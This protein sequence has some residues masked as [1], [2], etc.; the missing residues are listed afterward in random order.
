M[1]KIWRWL[2]LSGVVALS[3]C[4][5]VRCG[6]PMAEITP[7]KQTS[8]QVQVIQTDPAQRALW[9]K[10]TVSETDRLPAGQLSSRKSAGQ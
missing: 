4:Q 5:A 6:C 2:C 10:I 1:K 7:L 3:S 8:G 9:G